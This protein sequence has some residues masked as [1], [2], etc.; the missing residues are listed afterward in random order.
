MRPLINQIVKMGTRGNSFSAEN[1]AWT[2]FSRSI[3]YGFGLGKFTTTLF[4]QEF[5]IV[6]GKSIFRGLFSGLW[7]KL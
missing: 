1:Y 6:F 5:S 4:G 7:K 2:V 3:T